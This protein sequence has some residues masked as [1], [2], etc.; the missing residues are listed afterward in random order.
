MELDDSSQ[1]DL[2][3]RIHGQDCNENK[4]ICATALLTWMHE[5][6]CWKDDDFCTAI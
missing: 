5:I 1:T 6:V 3:V 2:Q 4:G